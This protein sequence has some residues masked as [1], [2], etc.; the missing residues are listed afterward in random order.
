[1][2][3]KNKRPYQLPALRDVIAKFDLSAKQCLGQ[4]FLLDMNLTRRIVREVG[5]L[6]NQVVLEIGPGPG[7]LTRAL[8]E[9]E[10]KMVF[11]IERDPRCVAAL[12]HLSGY[13]PGRLN[14]IEADALNFDLFEVINKSK[15]T[16]VAN[17]PY[18]ISLPLLM[19]Y[20]K[21]INKIKSMTLMFQKEV[22]DRLTAKPGTKTYGRIS[23]IA[24]WLCIVEK[25]L[26]IPPKAFV[27]PPKVHSN[28]VKFTPNFLH[29]DPILFQAMET[30]T[31]AA[32]GQRR[33]MLKSSLKSIFH[34]PIDILNSA[35]I[36]PSDR[37]ERLK[38]DDFFKISEL[39]LNSKTIL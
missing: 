30:V 32:F 4:N 24:Q 29:P 26:S 12:S 39:Y 9:T 17:L 2:L 28:I 27:P 33:K 15:I 38:V 36:D 35:K 8:L 6:K 14:V 10:A 1:L 5:N 23:V 31:A 7:G 22:A 13:F 37:A 18:N 25:K 3:H 16:I 21:K 11:A 34:N 19:S 20:L